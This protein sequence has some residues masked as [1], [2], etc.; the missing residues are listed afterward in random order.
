MLGKSGLDESVMDVGAEAVDARSV[1]LGLMSEALAH[2]DSDSN[3]PAAIGA[4]LQ[5]A[6]DALW[7]SA[8]KDQHSNQLQ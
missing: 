2:L 6:I 1:A 3:I 5:S 7:V 8:S 4:Y